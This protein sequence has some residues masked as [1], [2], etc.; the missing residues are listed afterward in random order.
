MCTDQ[1]LFEDITSA[2]VNWVDCIDILLPWLLQVH[3]QLLAGLAADDI[4]AMCT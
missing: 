2:A 3:R 4:Q 1:L